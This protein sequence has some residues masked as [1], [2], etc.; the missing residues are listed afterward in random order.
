MIADMDPVPVM[1]LSGEF[2]K[3]LAI[4][5]DQKDISLIFHPRTNE[6]SLD[7]TYETI[8]YR[9]FWKQRVREQFIASVNQYDADYTA[10]ILIQKSSKT[11]S[12]YGKAASGLEWRTFSFSRNRSSPVVTFGYT[13]KNETPYYT[14]T[15]EE[16]KNDIA[17]NG[18]SQFNSR[19]F[20]IYFTRAQAA[21]LADALNQ[22][23]LAALTG[24][25][26]PKIPD[27]HQDV[28]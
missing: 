6:V 10:H 3:F 23:S 21:S 24:N 25:G 20:R 12:V 16:G 8:K 26:A 18:D 11:R 17:G 2:D 15:L 13:F 14:V 19:R 9:L 22:E 28:Y 1:S 5:I 4:G 7:F 27:P